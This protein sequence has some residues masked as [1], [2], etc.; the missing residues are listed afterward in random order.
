MGEGAT[1]CRLP[2]GEQSP[3]AGRGMPPRPLRLAAQS[4]RAK[5][6]TEALKRRDLAGECFKKNDE[7]R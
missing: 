7:L 3:G 1:P 2:G 5:P 6:A 4:G